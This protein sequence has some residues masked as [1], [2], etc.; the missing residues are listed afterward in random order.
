MGDAVVSDGGTV[1][2]GNISDGGSLIFDAGVGDGGTMDAGC[3]L[4]D[5][6]DCDGVPTSLDCD[7]QDPTSTVMMEDAD[8]DGIPNT[9][10]YVHPEAEGPNNGSSTW[11]YAFTDLQDALLHSI[12]LPP[13]VDIWVAAGTYMPTTGDNPSIS[14]QLVDGVS[15]FGGFAGMES[16]FYD[17]DVTGNPTTL[18]GDLGIPGDL[19]DNS[20]HVVVSNN[21]DRSAVLD[22]FTITR[23]NARLSLEKFGG[24]LYNISSQ[25]TIRSCTF[26]ENVAVLTGG[27]MYNVESM[28]LISD[29]IFQGNTAESGGAMSNGSSAPEISDSRFINNTAMDGAAIYNLGSA[30]S[31]RSCSFDSNV[32]EKF[33]GAIYSKYSDLDNSPLVI[34]DSVFSNNR[35]QNGGGAMQI[36]EVDLHMSHVRFFQNQSE[37][38]GGAL[39]LKS[40]TDGYL[41]HVAFWG[42]EGER[43]GAISMEHSTMVISHGVFSGNLATLQGGAIWVKDSDLSIENATLSGNIADNSRELFSQDASVEIAIQNS[44]IWNEDG[45]SF[46]STTNSGFSTFNSC[47]DNVLLAGF[48]GEGNVYPCAP[49]FS[50]PLGSDGILGTE[51]D[52]LSLQ[53]ISD[54]VD[55][56]DDDEIP[57]DLLD[58]DE[59]GDGLEKVPWDFAGNPRISGE[60]VDIGAYEYQ[61]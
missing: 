4:V 26:L 41:T 37:N 39:R 43:G 8:C 35:S 27:G 32:A 36:E 50:D 34:S 29:S 40:L 17:R 42:N 24:G 33:G 22:G 30:G 2:A 55:Q 52:D 16:T 48:T 38:K 60:T 21:N 9:R 54:C 15:L 28:P 45:E 7:D 11:E 46:P 6:A 19:S 58:L 13:P 59:D 47:V 61:E 23:G 14:F 25:P 57:Q 1:D 20:H 51:D 12:E 3:M 18:S 31:L 5:D 49:A 10:L 56:G 44:I 53:S